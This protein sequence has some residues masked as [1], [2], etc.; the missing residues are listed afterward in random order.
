MSTK[1][2]GDRFTGRELIQLL[3]NP[4][5][6]A[7]NGGK[8]LIF[9]PPLVFQVVH[10][11]NLSFTF[12]L[13]DELMFCSYQLM[14]IKS[15]E[16]RL[17]G[18]LQSCQNPRTAAAIVPEN[19][20]QPQKKTT[21]MTSHPTFLHGWLYFSTYKPPPNLPCRCPSLMTAEYMFLDQN[22]TPSLIWNM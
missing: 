11:V 1:R 3:E 4:S 5:W 2:L 8:S 6:G 16:K 12:C 9:I 17:W 13:Y 18:I 7:R 21:I 14:S 15:S 19:Q 10:Y 20:K 22:S